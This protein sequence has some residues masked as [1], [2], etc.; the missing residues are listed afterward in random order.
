MY[1]I[2]L[3][4]AAALAAWSQ[5]PEKKWRDIG[6]HQ[7]FTSIAAEA[8]S[9]KR[10]GLLDLWT[11]QYPDSDFHKERLHLF[12][13]TY[14]VFGRPASAFEHTKELLRLDASDGTGLYWAVT[15]APSQIERNKSNMEMV[16]QW[17]NRLLLVLK[18]ADSAREWDAAA[19]KTLGWV[20]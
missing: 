14:Q 9:G 4:A 11:R 2:V 8:D 15:L 20:A 6:E 1:R 5:R 10:L 3:F 7:L 12:I 16:E 19:H 17:A 13:A 18:Q